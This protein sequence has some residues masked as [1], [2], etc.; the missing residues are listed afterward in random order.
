MAFS[1]KLINRTGFFLLVI[2]LLNS[3]EKFSKKGFIPEPGIALT[4]DDNRIDNWYNHL[5]LLD[6]LH[7]KATFYI[8]GYTR[9]TPVQKQ[10][11]AVIK[12]R[13]HEIGYHTVTHPNMNTYMQKFRKTMDQMMFAEIKTGLTAMEHDG[14]FPKVFAYPFGARNGFL[15]TEL[16]KYFISVRA[17]NGSMDYSKSLVATQKNYLI[18]GFGLDKSSNHKDEV[19]ADLLQN[20]AYHNNCAVLVGHDINTGRNLSVTKER[21]QLIANL[22]KENK[23]KTYTVSEISNN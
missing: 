14:F 2:L 23:L 9:L 5:D 6:S 16:K 20:S 1:F 22:V 8:S 11:L 15:D 18:Y 7:L 13:G 12:S 10:R 3:C 21:L 4:F 17:L 19:I